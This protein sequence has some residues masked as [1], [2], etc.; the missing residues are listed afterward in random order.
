MEW[1]G[2]GKLAKDL[3]FDFLNHL[4]K[5]GFGLSPSPLFVFLLGKVET[6]LKD[7]ALSGVNYLFILINYPFDTLLK[8]R[9]D[10]PL[11]Q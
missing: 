7:L 3:P 5:L 2:F 8:E 10:L 6:R 4:I 9:G 11:S 1:D